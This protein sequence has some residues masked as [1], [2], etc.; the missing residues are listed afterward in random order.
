M[1]DKFKACL[2]EGCNKNAHSRAQGARGW[3][4]MHYSRWR[5]HGDPKGG[6]AY[7]FDAMAFMLKTVANPPN[8]CVIWPYGIQGNGYGR[9]VYKG[10][11]LGA[12]R[13]AWELY[14]KRK[15]RPGMLACHKPIECHNRSCMNPLHI[16]E[17]SRKE[18]CEDMVL[19]GT[20]LLG[21]DTASAKLSASDVVRIRQLANHKSQT[22]I[23]KI[24]GVSV[25]NI[26]R[27]LSG[28]TWKHVGA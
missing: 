25:S 2:I 10:K 14:N 28:Q 13:L 9:V 16:R 17:A 23:A 4:R 8:E 27:I 3:C 5:A 21:E 12:H 20:R 18:N 11:V 15:L 22:E 24:F 26:S 19:D 6:R 1:A 7:H